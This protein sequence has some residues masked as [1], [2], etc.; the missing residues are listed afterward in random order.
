MNNLNWEIATKTTA[1]KVNSNKVSQPLRTDKEIYIFL[2]SS[3][4]RLFSTFNLGLVKRNDL[5]FL[6]QTQIAH[7]CL[8]N[9]L[10]FFIEPQDR[11]QKIVK[12]QV[13]KYLTSRIYSS[14]LKV[15]TGK[16][17]LRYLLI[18]LSEMGHFLNLGH[19]MELL[20]V[21]P[22]YLRSD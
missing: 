3:L 2:R 21:T 4:R 19:M 7:Q 18:N 9:K 12:I 6:R 1:R 13:L 17:C 11:A 14:N 22:F 16:I 20:L 8:V 15:K 10:D 5:N